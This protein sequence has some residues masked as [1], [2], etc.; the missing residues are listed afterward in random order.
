M[1]QLVPARVLAGLGRLCGAA[2]AA[3]APP[4]PPVATLAPARPA[5]RVRPPGIWPVPPATPAQGCADRLTT[6]THVHS[7]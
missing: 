1:G 3:A 5:A 4:R 2:G 7:G 6:E